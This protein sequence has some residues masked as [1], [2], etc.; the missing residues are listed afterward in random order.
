M[1]DDSTTPP[2]AESR[3]HSAA[4]DARPAQQKTDCDERSPQNS[5][6]TQFRLASLFIWLSV[7][8]FA[9]AWMRYWGFN[10]PLVVGFVTLVMALGP[11]S[12]AVALAR[13]QLLL[14]RRYPW[15]VVIVHTACVAS[16]LFGLLGSSRPD[17]ASLIPDLIQVCRWIA[18]IAIVMWML[19]W[20][21][22]RL[23]RNF[24][25]ELVCALLVGAL[26]PH[27]L[28]HV[29]NLLT[30]RSMADFVDE[31]RR[32]LRAYRYLHVLSV[33][34]TGV[35]MLPSLLAMALRL[36]IETPSATLRENAATRSER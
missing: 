22:D 18:S 11:I 8:A 15:T 7:I 32:I 6:P 35:F 34:S 33:V 14:R 24:A 20:A 1:T 23:L 16:I 27:I 17:Q 25:S 3:N 31:S 4:G 19:M 10:S 26:L 2:P 13:S 5:T 21:V 36:D 30:C 9:C 12:I 29:H 28:P